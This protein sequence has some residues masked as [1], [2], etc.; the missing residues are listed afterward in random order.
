MPETHDTLEQRIEQQDRI[1]EQMTH[2][3]KGILE[4]SYRLDGCADP[5]CRVCRDNRAR[6]DA[7]KEAV[8]AAEARLQGD[9]P[10]PPTAA[11]TD[12][13]REARVAHLE[14]AIRRAL[15]WIGPVAYYTVR[16]AGTTLQQGLDGSELLPPLSEDTGGPTDRA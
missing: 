2:A 9:D 7:A 5:T 1:I 14:E 12:S 11:Q 15:Q 16:M 10:A 3:L 13:V 6:I 8:A 4:I